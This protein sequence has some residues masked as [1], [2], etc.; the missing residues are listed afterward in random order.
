MGGGSGR[1]HQNLCVVTLFGR[2]GHTLTTKDQTV[3]LL[4]T[5]LKR[6]HHWDPENFRIRAMRLSDVCMML[7]SK[8]DR[9]M[10][11]EQ[12]SKFVCR[13]T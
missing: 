13:D 7:L 6:F 12:T 5:F 11:G 4:N 3:V 1:R 9:G 2:F 10:G 8:W